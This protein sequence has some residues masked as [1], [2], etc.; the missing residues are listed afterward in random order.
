VTMD[1]PVV[2]AGQQDVDA[3]A[4]VIADAFLPL[5]AG[6]WLMPDPDDRA[7]LYAPYFAMLVEH[8]VRHGEVYLAAGGDAVS[9]WFP[10][11]DEPPADPENY[12]ERLAALVGPY[13]ERYRAFDAMMAEVHPHEPHHYLA[14]LAVRPGRQGQG[15]G[16]ALLRDRLRRL[17]ADG[18]PAYLEASEPRSRDFYLREGFREHRP[19]FHLPDGTP[20]FPLWRDPR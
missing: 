1:V 3:A 16:A 20:L 2:R 9:V 5:P 10:P 17:D 15:L 7:R 13:L 12:E 11:S 4:A 14:F 19:P 8:A 18:V 6:L